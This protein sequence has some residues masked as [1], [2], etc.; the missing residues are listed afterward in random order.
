M[1]EKKQNIINISKI[2]IPKS[3]NFSQPLSLTN[4]H[5]HSLLTHTQ[6]TPQEGSTWLVPLIPFPNEVSRGPI[7][8][9]GSE[10]VCY[11]ENFRPF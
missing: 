5:A 9:Y 4:I 11:G 8:K 3:T 1:T 7:E 6:F 10:I 2:I